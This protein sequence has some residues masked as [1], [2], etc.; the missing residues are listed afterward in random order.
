MEVLSN[1]HLLQHLTKPKANTKAPISQ[2][3]GGG[4]GGANNNHNTNTNNNNTTSSW[5]TSPPE[6]WTAE[7]DATLRS[8]KGK[9]MGWKA[10][11]AELGDGHTSDSQAKA[12][13]KEIEGKPVAGGGGSDDGGSDKKD[14]DKKAKAEKAKAEGL[15]RQAAGKGKGKGGGSDG[16]QQKE[17]LKV[18]PP[19]LFPLAFSPIY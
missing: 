8:L 17:V 11:V 4:G 10:I 5:S 7:D 19:P 6:T 2:K 14:E 13:W 9:N 16:G 12:R 15:A 18:T 3:G 1:I